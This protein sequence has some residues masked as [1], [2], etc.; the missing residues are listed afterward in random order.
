MARST[1][2]MGTHEKRRWWIARALLVAGRAL[3]LLALPVLHRRAAR[4]AGHLVPAAA[5]GALHARSRP[6]G[7]GVRALA[8][9]SGVAAVSALGAGVA[10]G[11]LSAQAP[12]SSSTFKAGTVTLT[13]TSSQSC[14]VSNMAPGDSSAT[15]KPSGTLV[16]TGADRQ[17]SITVTYKGSV[18]AYLGLD[19]GVTGTAGTV[20]SPASGLF[21]GTSTGLQILVKDNQ[22]SPVTYVN[23][24]GYKAKS[25]TTVPMTYHSGTTDLL[26]S[27]TPF[28]SSSGAVTFTLDYDLPTTSTSGYQGATTT[29]KLTV[30]AVQS[31]GDAATGCTTGR[32]CPATGGFQWQ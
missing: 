11:L 20:S 18:S 4:R 31:K 15:Y 23:G 26:V 5:A 6:R 25:G 29:F 32:Q 2:S 17:C 27:T 30:H 21:D 3:G 24:T 14:T 7:R 10:F 8:V 22:S 16:G 19:I 9:T 1:L 12:S 28:T 13:R